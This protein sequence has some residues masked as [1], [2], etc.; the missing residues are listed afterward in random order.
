MYVGEP[1]NISNKQWVFFFFFSSFIKDRQRLIRPILVKCSI[2][3]AYISH[4]MAYIHDIY[5]LKAD[6]GNYLMVY[7]LNR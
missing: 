5:F 2:L 4:L 6:F 3:R 1:H 7:N